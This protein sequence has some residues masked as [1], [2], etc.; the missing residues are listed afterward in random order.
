MNFSA[1]LNRRKNA[2]LNTKLREMV[3][4]RENKPFINLFLEFE[5]EDNLTYLACWASTIFK[6]CILCEHNVSINIF[7]TNLIITFL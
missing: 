1:L 6:Y 7:T 3:S 2:L 5:A 4:W